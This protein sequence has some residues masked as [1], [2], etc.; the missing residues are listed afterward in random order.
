MESLAVSGN[1]EPIQRKIT[2]VGPEGKRFS[3][4]RLLGPPQTRGAP[5]RDGSHTRSHPVFSHP[6]SADN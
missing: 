2:R 6:R 1:V 5:R 3:C 4:P